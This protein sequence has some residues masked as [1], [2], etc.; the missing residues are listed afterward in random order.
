MKILDCQSL[1]LIEESLSCLLAISRDQLRKHVDQLVRMQF[2]VSADIVDDR[3]LPMLRHVSGRNFEDEKEGIT[4]WF[5]ATRVNDPNSFSTGIGSLNDRLEPTWSF[6]HSLIA[7][8]FT[9]TEWLQLRHEAEN[10]H[11]GHLPDVVR[12]WMSNHGPYAFLFADIPLNPGATCNHDYLGVPELVEFITEYVDRRCAT[13]LRSR[14]LSRTKPLL[15]K[16]STP[17]IL[18]M[19]VGAALD[20]LVHQKANWPIDC[21][22]PCFSGDGKAVRAEQI[23]KLIHVKESRSW[24]LKNP[25]YRLA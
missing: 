3:W 4:C 12:A 2:D 22:C 8:H 25:T 21:L 19:H 11:F 20:Y 15:V 18:A 5:H 6:L 9:E 23:I 16:F 1:H 10:D 17:G 7:D 14:H 13:N 24:D